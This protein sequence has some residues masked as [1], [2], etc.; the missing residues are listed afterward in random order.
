[1]CSILIIDKNGNINPMFIKANLYLIEKYNKKLSD[2]TLQQKNNILKELW[3][4][5]FKAKIDLDK[6]KVVGNYIKF[7]KEV[8]KT[9]FLIQWSN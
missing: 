7:S 6:C 2:T 8:Y 3:K 1:M 5:E 9:K 4:E